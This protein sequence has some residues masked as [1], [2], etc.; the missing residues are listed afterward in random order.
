MINFIQCNH[1]NDGLNV[2]IIKEDYWI[3]LIKRL[4]LGD[5]NSI[6]Y[7]KNSCIEYNIEIKNF[8]LEFLFFL[9]K[10]YP[11]S[12]K[13]MDNMEFISHSNN[14]NDYLLKYFI[15]SFHDLFKEL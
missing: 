10:K 7:I 11:E 5:E 14:I 3:K 1:T 4:K 15:Y 13:Y 2:K 12:I 8:I 6:N 9:I